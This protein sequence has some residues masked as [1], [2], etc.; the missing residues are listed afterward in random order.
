MDF[1]QTTL[2]SKQSKIYMVTFSLAKEDRLKSIA[3]FLDLSK[4]FDTLSHDLLLKKLEIYG[5]RGLSNKWFDSYIS[6]IQ[7]QVKCKTLSSNMT[8][9]SSKY[10]ITCGTVQGSCLGPLLSNIFCNDLYLNIKNCNLIMFAD[11]TTLYASH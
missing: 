8:E 11:N 9:S 1:T 3:I 5:I 4:A 6:N 10:Q 2:V 7:L